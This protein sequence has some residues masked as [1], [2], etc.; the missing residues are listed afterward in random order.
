MTLS[1]VHI[2]GPL[3]QALAIIDGQTWLYEVG[4][5]PR[6]PR[7]N[8][9]AL[10]FAC[11]VEVREVE[12]A[13]LTAH[14]LPALLHDENSQFRALRHMLAGM[15]A[16]LDDAFRERCIRAAERLLDA[17]AVD[18]FVAGRLIG[19]DPAD[20]DVTGAEKLARVSSCLRAARLYAVMAD[21]AVPRVEDAI[22]AWAA[23]QGLRPVAATGIGRHA[24]ENGLVAAVAVAVHLADGQRLRELLFDAQTCGWEPR[25][26]AHLVHVFA[27]PTPVAVPALRDED[28]QD[29]S[30]SGGAEIPVT[31]RN[32]ITAALHRHAGQRQ[33]RTGHRDGSGGDGTSRMEAAQ[34]QVDWIARRFAAGQT[35]AAWNDVAALL[36]QQSRH[37]NLAHAAKSLTNIAS[38]VGRHVDTALALCD[39]AE[40]CSPDDP[41]VGTVRAE[42]LRKAG[43]PEEALSAY[44]RTVAGFP[45]EVVARN[46]RAETLRELGRLEEALAAHDRTIVDFP[47]NV[48][49]RNG[50][51]ETLR[52]LGRLAEALCAYD[53]TIADFPDDVFART[54]RAETLRGLGRLEE[55]LAA[56]DRTIVDFPN[57]V[58]ARNGRAETLRELG[59]L[60]EAL[61]A[62]DQTI[63]DFP[64]NVV[65]RG[66][67]AETLRELGR[68]EEA[69]AAYDRTIVDFLDNVV[70]RDGRAETLRELGRLEEALVAYD[71]TAADFPNNVVARN[72]GAE[73]LR[74]LGRLAEALAAYD[75]TIADFP[76]NV[77]ARSGR[78]ETL[79]ELGR[80]E[81][82]LAAYDRTIVDFPNNVVARNGRAETLRE[83][84]RLE[85]ALTAYDRTVAD[86]PNDVF[87]RNGRA[88]TLREL[89]RLEEARDSY[90]TFHTLRPDV[91]V[92]RNGYAT[93]LCELGDTEGAR[94]VLDGVGD[95]PVHRQ[96]WIASHILCMI[97]L[98]RG[99]SEALAARMSN[100]ATTCPFIAQRRYFETAL[101]I[102][103]IALQRS[104][105]ARSR[106]ESLIATTDLL[107]VQCGALQL[108]KAHAEA[109]NDDLPAAATSLAVAANV[110]PYT[111]FLAA[112]LQRAIS[113]RFGL[114][115][116][117]APAQ[118]EVALAADQHLQQLEMG[119]VV[120]LATREWRQA[121]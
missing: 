45:N 55:A 12:P 7:N 93:I 63:V 56:Y 88:E 73:T 36:E 76:N 79:R 70:A 112:R 60:E 86:F 30:W 48:V 117:A 37:G 97:E 77:V 29:E 81:E 59:R 94:A 25:L 2:A 84:G 51:A 107:P 1:A 98:R 35:S 5:D 34:Q 72:G 47:N 40:A 105:E 46:G 11:G 69:L 67:R 106:L 118:P 90:A 3:G 66:G 31:A 14:Q 17:P 39:L 95:P 116:T 74:E 62:Y 111:H 38:R 114:G 103:E 102:L 89:G 9:V 96:D 10:F 13:T 18:R 110:V 99:P 19:P 28:A 61:A 120:A 115:P 32:R 57:N 64:N 50:R 91:L 68:L 85:E 58:V 16:E 104:A 113:D 92:T 41:T 22:L 109:A 80:L 52:E 101:A 6:P 119:L 87:A 26:V 27:P 75:R 71:R 49:G 82:A 83:F 21:P 44:D 100:L 43:R 20:W 53:R 121:A 8:D 24:R 4:R 15:D 33:R 65:A 108:I 23:V 42:A 78:A 54:G